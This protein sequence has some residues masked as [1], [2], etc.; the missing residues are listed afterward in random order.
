MQKTLPTNGLSQPI[1]FAN[2]WTFPTNG[3]SQPIGFPNQSTFPT[4]E[5]WFALSPLVCSQASK[6]G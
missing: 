4:K 1:D 3:L 2:Q 6:K 5:L